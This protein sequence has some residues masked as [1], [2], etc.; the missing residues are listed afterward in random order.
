MELNEAVKTLSNEGFIVEGFFGN[1]YLK[2]KAKVMAAL[3]KL[4]V[5][6]H[7]Q[8]ALD[9]W[10]R[11]FF[12][13]RF[14]VEECIQSCREN[15]KSFGKKPCCECCVHIN[16]HHLGGA[17]SKKFANK[18]WVTE[19]S[20]PFRGFKEDH[21]AVLIHTNTD[22]EAQARKYRDDV[23]V[24]M[25]NLYGEGNV[26]IRMKQEYEFDEDSYEDLAEDYRDKWVIVVQKEF[27]DEEPEEEK[28]GYDGPRDW[29]D[30]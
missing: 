10:I 14:D 29:E 6:I 11:D 25:T 24:K 5:E 18:Q 27:N 23:W 16:D 30:D 21:S 19:I 2:Y 3:K 17:V 4:G 28:E 8:K 22:S 15:I 1:A 7:N 9:S 20:Y 13:D 26:S 12:V